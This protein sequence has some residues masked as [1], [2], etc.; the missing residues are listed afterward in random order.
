MLISKTSRYAL[1][2]AT[3]LAKRWKDGDVVQAREI[4]EHTGV[5]QNYLSK[6][7]HQLAR[8]GVLVSERGPKGGFRLTMD[9]AKTNLTAILEPVEGGLT[10]QHCLLGRPSCSDRDPC[11]AHTGWKAL[12]VELTR[13]LDETVLADLVEHG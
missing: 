4:A 11:L 3:Y 12:S 13:F 2:A 10:E 7:L 9:P 1:Q 8:Q 5:P 6:I